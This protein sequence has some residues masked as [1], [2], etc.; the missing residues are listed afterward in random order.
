[1]KKSLKWLGIALLVL[2]VLPLAVWIGW[3]A[4]DEKLDPKAAAFGAVRAP[5]VPDD[6]NAHFPVI[7]MSAPDGADAVE[8]GKAWVAEARA[9]ARENRGEKRAEVKRAKRPAMCDPV[10]ASCVTAAR[11]KPTEAS[12]QLNA[13]REDFE[14]Y[15]KL[16]RYKRYEEVLD[17]V[18]RVDAMLPNYGGL[19]ETHRAYLMRVAVA[20]GAGDIEEGLTLLEQ[21]LQFQRMLL[22]GTRSLLGKMLVNTLYVRDLAFIADLLQ[23]HGEQLK[24]HAARLA[25]MAPPLDP[26]ALKLDA[27]IAGE[28]RW[29]TKAIQ[30]PR[31]AGKNF[32]D[33]GGFGSILETGGMGLFYKKNATL[34]KAYSI[35]SA[36]G[37]ASLAPADGFADAWKKVSVVEN[38]WRP[39]LW[40]F[41]DNPVGKILLGMGMPQLDGYVLR[42]HD[43]DA[44]NRLVGLRIA[45]LEAGVALENVQT[46]VEKAD[47]RFYDPY[48]KKPMAW[49]VAA[50]RLS[51]KV[52]EFTVKRQYGFVDKGRAFLQW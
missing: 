27:V 34:N 45:M 38:V 44:I 11:E 25:A 10:K 29:I 7:G 26:F 14:R 35:Y 12:T 50:R 15:E 2:V 3:N 20:I 22:G 31:S 1:M 40:D 13:Y 23:Q 30:D 19:S 33:V 48:V 52:S 28:Y 9:A 43:M 51:V 24:P 32:G 49:D 17:Y 42:M 18:V 47:A 4:I 6:E 8:Y 5:A 16:L 46:F 39:G 41:F 37:E 36:M 21:E